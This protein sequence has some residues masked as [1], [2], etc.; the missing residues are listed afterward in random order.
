[1][2]GGMSRLLQTVGFSWFIWNRFAFQSQPNCEAEFLTQC[3]FGPHLQKQSLVMRPNFRG[4]SIPLPSNR[5]HPS[6]L[7]ALSTS[8]QMSVKAQ[9]TASPHFSK[10]AEQFRIAAKGL[11]DSILAISARRGST[12]NSLQVLQDPDF[13]D[14]TSV[15]AN[16]KE[17]G[18]VL[19]ALVQG[20][21]EYIKNRKGIDKAKAI[22]QGWFKASYPYAKALVTEAKEVL[23]VFCCLLYLW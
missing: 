5:F 21:D 9:P 14:M 1:M 3:K 13:G 10:S 19:D 2:T 17:L 8:S 22:A 20:R 16:A 18:K 6:N 23:V 15:T 7:S 12:R 11:E 4:G